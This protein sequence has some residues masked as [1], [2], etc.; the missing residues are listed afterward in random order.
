MDSQKETVEEL[1]SLVQ[2]S[3]QHTFDL[4]AKV[5]PV[6]FSLFQS[7]ISSLFS[8]ELEYDDLG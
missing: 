6:D 7:N 8:Q 2:S 3:I 4:D 5:S 1:F